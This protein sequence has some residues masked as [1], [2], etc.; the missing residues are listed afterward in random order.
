MRQAVDE[1][2]RLPRGAVLALALH[3]SV[4]CAP[5]SE[6]TPRVAA[7][8]ERCEVRPPSVP[9]FTPEMEWAWT[10]SPIMPRHNQ[11]MTTPA[12]A[13]VSQDG[14]PDVVFGAFDDSFGADG[15]LRAISGDDGRDLWTVT[16][17]TLRVRGSGHI[18]V[19]NIDSDPQV[20]ICAIAEDALGFICFE[21]DGAFKL[22]SAIAFNAWGGISFADLDG[23]GRVEIL[24]GNHVFNATG[25][26]KW[27]GSDGMGGV[28]GTAPI[29]FAADIDQDGLQE[30]VNDRAVYRHDGTLKCANTSISHGL[31]A[32]G[33]FDA[34]PFGE[35][36]VSS[37]GSVTLLDDTCAR[38]WS[39]PIPGDGG[40]GGPPNIADLDGDGEPEIGVAGGTAYSV[41]ERDG[42]LK[43]S[44]PTHDLSSGSTGSSS[45]DFEGDG[46]AEVVYADEFRLRIYDGATGAVRF[47]VP[48]SSRTIHENPV[49]ADV[50]GDGNAEIVTIANGPLRGIRVYRDRNDGWVNTRRIWNQHAYSVT[51]V[52]DDGS[53][54]AH[55]ETNW[56]TAGLNTFRSNRQGTGTTPPFA[57]PD[58]VAS[59]V[60]GHCAPGARTV[61]LSAIVRN[62]G[63]AAASAGLKVAFYRG[64]PASGGALLGV[65]SVPARL[66]A[67]AEAGVGLLLHPPPGGVAQVWAVAD[68][69][70]T[71]TGREAECIETNNAASAT[72]D[73]GCSA[74]L[75]PVAVCRDVTLSAG[76]ACA[77]SAS[78]DDGSHDPDH[79]PGP[80]VITEAPAGPFGLGSHRVTLTA[81]DGAAEDTCQGTVTVV[82]AQAPAL[83]GS[84]GHVL[85]P[86]DHKYRQLSL[87]DCAEDP[88]DQCHGR[89]PLDQYGTITRV[90]SDEVE[91]ACDA[92]DGHTCA[93]I[94]ITG[95]TTMK[96]RAERQGTSDGR[97][98]TLHYTVTD[99]SGNTAAS[100]CTVT[101]PHDATCGDPAADSGVAY[102]VGQGCPDGTSGSPAC[103]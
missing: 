32:V 53:I 66:E 42:T 15:V 14:I 84:K 47:E 85:W 98:Y 11:V 101:V 59:A 6:E 68:D 5:L 58:L 21:H 40:P 63:D 18:A 37:G 23:D 24:D 100:S 29:S 50:D 13:D 38:L 90:T 57:A 10:G 82:D 39:K 99:P 69:D 49:V 73:L 93:D 4:A 83:G 35:I 3:A 56:L 67:G 97:V 46:R 19:G 92:G 1:G 17:P 30:V 62:Q 61:S 95:R 44:Q 51:N 96:L 76:A 12:V 25:G 74:N 102:C 22:R 75:P 45:F 60:A 41:F 70:G 65:A 89:L 78:V 7:V 86:P 36:A 64:N 71:G 88:V 54:P 31:A 80:L 8:A 94:V 20:E 33:N 34:D 48:H 72:V 2:A 16:D 77:A 103:R 43:W 87:S 52:N 28:A 81:S 79:Q 55:P 9:S 91:D 27:V 26:L